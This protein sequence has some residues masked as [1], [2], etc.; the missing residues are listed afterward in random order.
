MMQLMRIAVSRPVALASLRVALVVGTVLNVINLGPAILAG[1]PASWFH[2][3]LNY[4]VPF[5]VASYSAASAQIR[6][7]GSR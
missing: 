2:A 1:Q 6:S 4:L 3:G 5:C 7:E